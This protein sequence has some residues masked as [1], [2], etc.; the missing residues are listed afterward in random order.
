MNYEEVDPTRPATWTEDYIFGLISE[1]ADSAWTTPH[2]GDTHIEV[3][4]PI[5]VWR[6]FRE[7]S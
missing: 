5:E 7:E 2:P 3:F 1:M 6:A 4:M